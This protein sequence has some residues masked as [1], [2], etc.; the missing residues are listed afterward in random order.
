MLGPGER[1]IQAEL[2]A[3]FAEVGAGL[4]SM[5]GRELAQWLARR[6]AHLEHGH[7][8][9]TIGHADIFACPASVR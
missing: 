4:G 1:R 7:S 3:S 5:N 9:L 6:R 8:S 2:L